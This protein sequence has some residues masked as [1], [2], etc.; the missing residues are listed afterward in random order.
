MVVQRLPDF[1]ALAVAA[2]V[3]AAH[4][5]L[6][7]GELAHHVGHEVRLHEPCRTHEHPVEVREAEARGELL[8]EVLNAARLLQVVAERLLEL[9]PAKPR[10]AVLELR[11]P[12]VV[13]E[14]ARVREARGGDPLVA[15][16]DQSLRVARLVADGEK[17]RA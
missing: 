16:R 3:E 6:Q 1:L 5:A 17:V 8:G 2:C 14:E 7:V 11:L 13:P 9:E 4:D 12:V 10:E 15:L